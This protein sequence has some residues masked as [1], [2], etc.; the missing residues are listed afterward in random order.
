MGVSSV[1][2]QSSL[3]AR[4]LIG[5]YRREVEVF[6]QLVG[7]L[8]PLWIAWDVLLDLYGQDVSFRAINS[9]SNAVTYYL[10]APKA[11][12]VLSWLMQDL[13]VAAA[14]FAVPVRENRGME[15][16]AIKVLFHKPLLSD[17]KGIPDA[18]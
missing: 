10:T 4:K 14:E 8:P 12:D 7:D 2:A 1:Q 18:E 11:T 5:N 13:R 6:N 16:F 17:G 9:S 3:E 15:E